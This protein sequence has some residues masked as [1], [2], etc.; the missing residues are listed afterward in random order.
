[1]IGY[2]RGEVLAIIPSGKA[3]AQVVVWPNSKFSEDSVGVAYTIVT[4]LHTAFNCVV[5]DVCAFWTYSVHHENDNY[6]I[7]VD[8]KDSLV[9]F[10]KLL[11]VSGVGPRTAMQIVSVLGVEGVRQDVEQRE[12]KSIAKVPGVGQKTASKIILELAGKLLDI[13]KLV[14]DIGESVDTGKFGVVV[15]TLEKLGYSR[16]DAKEAVLRATPQL[17]EAVDLSVSQQVSLVLSVVSK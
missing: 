4:S 9:M 8:T 7:G 14:S 1:M 6:L 5:G 3:A 16:N 17:S 11:D 2:I 13:G 15:S 10:V 12:V